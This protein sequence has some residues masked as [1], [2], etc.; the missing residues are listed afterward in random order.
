MCLLT[1]SGVGDIGE[2]ISYALI[3]KSKLSKLEKHVNK[4]TIYIMNML[5]HA[6][7]FIKSLSIMHVVKI[8]ECQMSG[9]IIKTLAA[10]LQVEVLVFYPAMLR[11]SMLFP[12][13]FHLFLRVLV[14]SLPETEII[15][16]FETDI[17]NHNKT[18]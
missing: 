15:A 11:P 18:F 6:H 8:G 4:H 3:N 7:L 2:I 1:F 12:F 17:G 16:D 10:A 5:N 13:R 9:R 14:Y